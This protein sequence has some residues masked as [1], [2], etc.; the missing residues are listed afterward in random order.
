LVV[1]AGLVAGASLDARRGPDGPARPGQLAVLFVGLFCLL[2]GFVHSA[3]MAAF[4]LQQLMVE[5]LV[6]RHTFAIE[7]SRTAEFQDIY[8]DDN[9][10]F[11]RGAH[12]FPVKAPGLAVLA[13]LPYAVIH[14]FHTYARDY[15]TTSAWVTLLSIVA[16]VAAMGVAT[17]VLVRAI[18]GRHRAAALVA[19]CLVFGTPVFAYSGVLYHDLPA[20]A[21]LWLG[22]VLAYFARPGRSTAL[23][24]PLAAGCALGLAVTTSFLAGVVA[25]GTAVYFLWRNDRRR[26]AVFLGGL[27]A[28]LVPLAVYDTYYF[29]SALRLSHAASA[30]STAKFLDVLPVLSVSN[31]LDKAAFYLVRPSNALLMY[32]PLVLAGLAGLVLAPAA[33]RRE[34]WTIA[35]LCVAQ[36]AYLLT[37][38]TV[39][40]CM[41]GP[42]YLVFILPF[43][44]VGLAWLL[45]RWPTLRRLAR[46]ALALL[47]GGSLAINLLGAIN[48]VMQCELDQNTWWATARA[49]AAGSYAWPTFPFWPLSIVGL[50]LLAWFVATGDRGSPRPAGAG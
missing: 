45:E 19:V 7:G 13:G 48:T 10:I 23:W 50:A 25:A 22:F 4:T 28:G 8:D 29:G 46:A 34:R 39:G 36:L 26:N 35:A 12:L 30:D 44:V 6:E 1:R 16:L 9:D 5:S 40:H 21:L 37:I 17:Y 31:L 32:S 11:R 33:W 43:L 42:R 49:I 38:D 24:L 18:T 41:F 3:N 20:T 15:L 14:P 2:G 47:I 27:A